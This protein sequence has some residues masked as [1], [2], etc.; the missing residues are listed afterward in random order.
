MRTALRLLG[1]GWLL[2]VR[3]FATSAF[4]GILNVLYPLF[5]ATVAFFMFE[6][7][8]LLYASLGAAVMGRL[9]AG[10]Q[11][12]KSAGPRPLLLTLATLVPPKYS[13]AEPATQP[14]MS[15]TE[16]STLRAGFLY[17]FLACS[18]ASSRPWAE[19]LESARADAP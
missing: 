9:T 16:P 1:V 15:S 5:F 19:R 18:M 13:P 11:L 17:D 8:A 7:D 14:V 3:M 2:H 4:N 10:G 12:P 6:P